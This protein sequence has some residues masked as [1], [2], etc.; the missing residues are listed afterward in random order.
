M[1]LSW[2]GCV[3]YLGEWGGVG[4]AVYGDLVDEVNAV[5]DGDEV[6]CYDFRREGFVDGGLG[7]DFAE[8]VYEVC[9]F[10]VCET[11]GGVG[12]GVIGGHAKTCQGEE[13][14][15]QWEFHDDSCADE[16]SGC[17]D[18]NSGVEKTW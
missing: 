17:T 16:D 10:V 5:G 18:E 14:G 3:S 13:A 6:L 12:A 15:C 7:D 4:E 11:L 1:V 9:D 2:E 8:A